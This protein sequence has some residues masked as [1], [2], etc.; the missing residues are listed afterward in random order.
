MWRKREYHTTPFLRFERALGSRQD[1]DFDGCVPLFWNRLTCCRFLRGYIDCPKS[2]NVL[3][4]S[5]YTVIFTLTLALTLTLTL[6]LALALLFA[7]AL[8]TLR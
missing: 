6:T 8:L 7:L 2:N 3:D 5:L 1:L 4:K